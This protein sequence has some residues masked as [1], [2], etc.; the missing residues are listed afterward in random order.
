MD[1]AWISNLCDIASVLFY[2]FCKQL[3]LECF[4]LMPKIDIHHGAFLHL[5]KT[6]GESVGSS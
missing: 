2:P 1:E 6:T 4:Y 3:T 5:E